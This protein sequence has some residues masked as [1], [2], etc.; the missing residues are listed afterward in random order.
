MII[1]KDDW[2]YWITFDQTIPK[3]TINAP[4]N[5]TDIEPAYGFKIIAR[6]NKDE[7]IAEDDL[8]IIISK[9]CFHQCS[10]HY[11]V[12]CEDWSLWFLTTVVYGSLLFIIG[13]YTHGCL[14]MYY[15]YKLNSSRKIRIYRENEDLILLNKDKNK[16]N[17][18]DDVIITD[19]T[20]YI[21]KLPKKPKDLTTIFNETIYY[22][23]MKCC[24]LRTR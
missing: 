1:P 22:I 21:G 3:I 13:M 10:K 24:C 15:E 7:S 19:D 17:D 14:R 6:S 18:K 8:I 20:I 23:I 11:G 2:P 4:V 5:I 16:D 9:K 12:G